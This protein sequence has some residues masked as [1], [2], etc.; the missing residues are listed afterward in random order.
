MLHPTRHHNLIPGDNTPRVA[1]DAITD[2]R[3]HG[4][5][6]GSSQ[7][8]SHG[9]E[10]AA[11]ENGGFELH[12]PNG[13][14][15][16]KIAPYFIEE[17]LGHLGSGRCNDDCDCCG[18]RTC[19]P[20]GFCDGDPQLAN[21]PDCAP[22]SRATRA[23][24]PLPTTANAFTDV[25]GDRFAPPAPSTAE[26]ERERLAHQVNMREDFAERA[27]VDTEVLRPGVVEGEEYAPIDDRGLGMNPQYRG[28]IDGLFDNAGMGH[29]SHEEGVK[30]PN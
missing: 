29:R 27:G 18:A 30:N 4:L 10:D 16:V 23:F 9:M 22:I 7:L 26:E 25:R 19:T 5:D 1:L 8:W 28:R 13:S 12:A 17:S 15:C 20:H 14:T 21:H 3:D 11:L 2:H 24:A 6:A